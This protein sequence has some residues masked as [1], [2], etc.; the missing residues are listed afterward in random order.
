[1]IKLGEGS[2]AATPEDTADAFVYLAA[3]HSAYVTGQILS[4]DDVTER[5]NGVYPVRLCQSRCS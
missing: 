2:Q 3:P 5:R 4:V 1:L